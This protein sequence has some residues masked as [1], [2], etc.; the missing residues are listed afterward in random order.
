M[1]DARVDKEAEK[2]VDFM[3]ELADYKPT[4]L[5]RE[6]VKQKEDILALKQ[7]DYDEAK[8]NL[9][10]KEA[11]KKPEARNRGD[12]ARINRLGKVVQETLE[13]LTKANGELE[14]AK[15]DLSKRL[16]KEEEEK[17]DED[18]EDDLDF[19]KK[20]FV[21]KTKYLNLKKK[22]GL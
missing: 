6:I 9:D 11:E 4:A 13:K 18:D 15:E 5:L 16:D 3:D 14:K 1:A 19:M 10:A 2:E 7:A 22:L 17:D 21:Y 20:Y 12:R 8:K